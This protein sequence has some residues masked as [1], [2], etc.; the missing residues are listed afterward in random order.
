MLNNFPKDEGERDAVKMR[1]D[2]NH[3]RIAEELGVA[4]G[5]YNK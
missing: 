4:V 3:T 2:I 5:S 1:F